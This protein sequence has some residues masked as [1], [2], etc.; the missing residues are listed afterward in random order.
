MFIEIFV[1][2]FTQMFVFIYIKLNVYINVFVRITATVLLTTHVH[3]II[4]CLS[5]YEHNWIHNK[6]IH[7]LHID[8]IS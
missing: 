6:F 4:T 1:T 3:I 8:I 5:M 7:M 2:L